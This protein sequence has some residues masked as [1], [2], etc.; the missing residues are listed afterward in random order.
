MIRVALSTNK[1]EIKSGNFKTREEVDQWIL[2]I[3]ETDGVARYRIKDL[4][5]GKIIETERG[6]LDKD[7]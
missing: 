1:G 5:T 3:M 6:R 4:T 2:K 7:E